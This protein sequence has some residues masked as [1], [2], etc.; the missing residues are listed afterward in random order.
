LTIIIASLVLSGLA[1]WIFPLKEKIG[2]V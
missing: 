2:E 1:S